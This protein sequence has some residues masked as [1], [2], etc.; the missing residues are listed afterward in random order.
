MLWTKMIRIV[1]QHFKSDLL[2]LS[3]KLHQILSDEERLKILC[4]NSNQSF[5]MNGSFSMSPHSFTKLS[6]AYI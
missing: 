2:E 4:R 1:C 5:Y 6:L 3:I